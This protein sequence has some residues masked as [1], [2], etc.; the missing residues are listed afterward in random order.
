[1]YLSIRPE[2][3]LSR[4][5]RSLSARSAR[6]L[7]LLS[8]AVAAV[9]AR[10]RGDVRTRAAQDGPA[11]QRRA[12]VRLCAAQLAD[13]NPAGPLLR[14]LLDTVQHARVWAGT[15]SPSNRTCL[16]AMR[17]ETHLDSH[18]FERIVYVGERWRDRGAAMGVDH[19]LAA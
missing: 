5:E 7:Q 18:S 10:W 8:F 19:M 1:M 14:G 3:P 17:R 13:Y 2:S 4:A 11:E 16:C 15:A 6:P 9:D 12:F